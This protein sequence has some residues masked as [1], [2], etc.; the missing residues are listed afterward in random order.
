MTG[1]H[2]SSDRAIILTADKG[3]QEQA[4]EDFA[5]LG[6]VQIQGKSN[7]LCPH[8]EDYTCLEGSAGKCPIWQT[9]YCN[10]WRDMNKARKAKSVIT[11]YSNWI[12]IN[13]FGKGI[14]D[15]DRLILDE[16]HQAPDKLSDAI[17]ISLSF[18]EIDG[19]LQRDIPDRAA[20]TEHWK[21]WAQKQIIYADLLH[22]QAKLDI[23]SQPGIMSIRRYH[24][25]QEV[26]RK[27]G[28]LARI[29]P[30]DWVVD[31]GEYGFKFDAV[32]P[33]MYAEKYLFCEIPHLEFYSGTIRPK[34]LKLLNVFNDYTFLDHPSEFDPE[35]FKIYL[36]PSM[37]LDRFADSYESLR[38]W[39]MR[40]DQIIGAR[41]DRK[42]IIH[43]GSFKRQR[44]ITERSEY[45][46][47]MVWNRKGESTAD[48]VKR[49]RSAPE[50]SVFV[51]PSIPMGYDFLGAD[52]EYQIIGKVPFDDPR[53]KVVMARTRLDGEYGIY[54]AVQRLEQMIGR[55][56]RDKSDSCENF[57]L[58]EHF[59]WIIDKY[60]HLFSKSFW[61]HYKAVTGLPKPLPKWRAA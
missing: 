37:R 19:I 22:E 13:R 52:C 46:D 59:E 42:G 15:F 48:A 54:Q 31:E 30:V 36:V 51:S 2:V 23:D 57:L 38:V 40:I 16:A 3:L 8:G 50:G 1:V 6:L 61:K 21:E 17:S 49:F 25:T 29:R 32:N 34:T 47:R 11:N 5:E 27:V 24:K 44:I 7:Y 10:W 60:R 12:S 9:E 45:A 20:E 41:L 39:M 53:D 35:R 58:D 14:G 26:N 4:M 43:C 33:A 55:G 56:M 28:M 18:R